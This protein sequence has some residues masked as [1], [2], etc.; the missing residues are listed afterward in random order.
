MSKVVPLGAEI[1]SISEANCH[2]LKKGLVLVDFYAT[3]CGPCKRLAPVFL[4]FAQANSTPSLVFAK[5]DSDDN[6]DLV[7][8]FNIEGLPTV[9]LLQDGN[10]VSTAA[11]CDETDL[12]N[13]VDKAVELSKSAVR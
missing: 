4:R 8:A 12:A 1:L 10:V 5:V 2:R 11:G 13:L 6:Q 9:L 7:E 3:W